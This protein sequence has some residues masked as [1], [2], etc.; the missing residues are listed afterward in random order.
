MSDSLGIAQEYRPPMFRLPTIKGMREGIA[1]KLIRWG[2]DMYPGESNSIGH[3]KT[4]LKL[5]GLFDKDSDYGGALG[6]AVVDLMKVF[7]IEGHSGFSA[8]LTTSLFERVSRHEILTPLTGTDDEWVIHDYGD[9]SPYAQNR[10][11]GHVF[12]NADGTA[13]DIDGKVFR[14][15]SGFTYTSFES[16]VP[17]TFPYMPK[18]EYVDVPEPV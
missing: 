13:Y 18:R 5:A 4:E 6:D 7:A 12:K 8:S 9:G 14:E 2:L 15:P 17:V 11:C 10:R 3:A 1:R 16:R